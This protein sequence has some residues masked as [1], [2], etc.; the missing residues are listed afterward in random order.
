MKANRSVP[1]PWGYVLSGALL[2]MLVIETTSI[3]VD[4]WMGHAA[5]PASSVAS[6]ALTPVFG[7]L[8]LIGLVALV[9]FLRHGRREASRV[10]AG[11]GGRGVERPA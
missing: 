6:D 4:Q 2:V 5:D 3:G 11:A 1:P 7:V 8:T 10:G 9:L